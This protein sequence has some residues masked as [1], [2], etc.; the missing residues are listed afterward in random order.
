M[1]ACWNRN[2]CQKPEGVLRANEQSRVGQRI[3]ITAIYPPAEVSD[4]SPAIVD[5]S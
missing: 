2:L 3:G 5:T 1:G 4:I